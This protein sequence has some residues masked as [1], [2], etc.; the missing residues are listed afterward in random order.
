M[1]L[2]PFV[3][4]ENLVYYLEGE[5]T[6]FV[7]CDPNPVDFT[8]VADSFLSIVTK[9]ASLKVPLK[10]QIDSLI[11]ILSLVV[12]TADRT[13]VAWDIKPVLTYLKW[14]CT[15]DTYAG[16][17]LDRLYDLKLAEAAVGVQ[18]QAPKSWAEAVARLKVCT[19]N[20]ATWRLHRRLHLPL[21]LSVIP[22][23]E[24]CGVV[25]EYQ[26][27]SLYP[28]YTV[29]GQVHGRMSCHVAF[30][31]CV[32]PHSLDDGH[33]SVL[34]PKPPFDLFVQMDYRAMEAR[35]LA[36]LTK[37]PVL[38]AIISDPKKDVYEEVFKLVTGS[39]DAGPDERTLAKRFFLP[40][41]F[42][43]Q[44]FGLSEAIG[45][46][47]D[48]AQAIITLIAEK[49]PVAWAWTDQQHAEAEKTGKA[50]DVFGRTRTLES[51]HQ[52]RSNN[53][54][55]PAAA[56]CLDKLVRLH[57]A[58]DPAAARIAFSIH[59]GYVLAAKK[60]SWKQTVIT[61]RKVLEADEEQYKGLELKTSCEVGK[62]L[63]KMNKVY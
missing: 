62:N 13:V 36:W 44:A 37:D 38:T 18:K 31:R 30:P 55:A 45:V 9:K 51:P 24:T 11:G 23:I 35:V 49:F 43:Q 4:G 12:F 10:E 33:K 21:A 32:N 57:K 5:K 42:G 16:L 20:A 59:D 27:K 1:S 40:V 29:E 2:D 6:V 8:N 22:A 25:D 52:A 41:F 61:A 3:I 47:K 56:I 48:T 58:L 46:G 14:H 26:R 7:K 17:N 54:A 53:I 34:V 19:E 28:S 63:G 39:E 50:T 60:D 15:P